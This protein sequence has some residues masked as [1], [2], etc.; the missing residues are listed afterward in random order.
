MKELKKCRKR[1]INDLCGLSGSLPIALVSH[2]KYTSFHIILAQTWQVDGGNTLTSAI[3]F[4][5][6]D[7]KERSNRIL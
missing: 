5:G 4:T 3:F 2:K 1:V 7:Y 6:F